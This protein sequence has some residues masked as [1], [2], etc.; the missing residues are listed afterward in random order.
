MAVNV[1]STAG[2]GEEAQI[3]ITEDSKGLTIVIPNHTKV[4]GVAT[5]KG[6]VTIATT[7]GNILLPSNMNLSINL[8]QRGPSTG[9]GNVTIK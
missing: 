1:Q 9:R 5:A 4:A 3:N 2:Q 6:N 8:W 7:H